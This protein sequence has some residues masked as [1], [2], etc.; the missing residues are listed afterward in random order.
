MKILTIFF[1][2]FL[3]HYT[4]SIR[5]KILSKQNSCDNAKEYSVTA[6]A[7]GSIVKYK[8]R[9]YKAR[10][11]GAAGHQV[12]WDNSTYND[13][14]GWDDITSTSTST[15]PTDID[16][17]KIH[18]NC[19]ECENEKCSKYDNNY[20]HPS[21]E[22]EFD[23]CEDDVSPSPII[24]TIPNTIV[25]N[26]G[27]ELKDGIC[28]EIK[29]D[30]SQYDKNCEE[31]NKIHC[32]KCFTNYNLIDNSCQTKKDNCVDTDEWSREIAN[33]LKSPWT[34]SSGQVVKYEGNKYVANWG[35]QEIPGSRTCSDESDCK[36]KGIQWVLISKC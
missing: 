9:C 6:W 20:V 3:C 36:N 11:V 14:S 31:C 16:C 27:F 18:P 26:E 10:I 24:P 34:Y 21:R 13:I 5:I 15:K 33:G 2:V 28:I 19:L 22:T 4:S 8:D 29:V 17:H 7:G 1:I 35:G 32:T 23:E 12:P 30:C 25:C